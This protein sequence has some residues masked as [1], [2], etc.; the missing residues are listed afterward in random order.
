VA[1][2]ALGLWALVLLP[3][4][5]RVAALLLLAGVATQGNALFFILPAATVIWVEGRRRDLAWLLLPIGAFVLYGA[6]THDTANVRGTFTVGGILPFVASG[7][8]D[9]LTGVFGTTVLGLAGLVL[10]VLAR[11]RKVGVLTLVALAGLLGEFVILASAR[12]GFSDPGSSQYLDAATPFVLMIGGELLT[13]ARWKSLARLIAVTV[14]A[15]NLI[16][17]IDSAGTWRQYVDA[18]RAADIVPAGVCY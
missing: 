13:S 12:Q 2:I 9:A 3:S 10:V 5:P 14:L 17:L 15:A 4:H 6:L 16:F 7:L 1:A 11:P 18:N 8:A